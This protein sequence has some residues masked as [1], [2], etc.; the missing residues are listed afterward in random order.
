[1]KKILSVLG[2]VVVFAAIQLLMSIAVM[3]PWYVSQGRE[4]DDILRGIASGN[5]GNTPLLLILISVASS[6]VTILLFGLLKWC[7]VSRSYLRTRPWAVLFWVV[8]LTL[9]TL[10]PSEVLQEQLDLSMDKGLEQLFSAMMGERW[11]YLAIGILA[12]IAE[13]MVFRGAILRTLLKL[14]DHRWHWLSILFSA[15]LFGAVHG[16]MPQFVHATLLGLLLGWLYYRTGSIIPGIVLH[17][18]NNTVAYVLFNLMPQATDAKLIDLFGGNDR[19]VWL[20]LV[21]SLCILLPSLFQLAVRM[22]RAA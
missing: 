15:L 10:I 5:I 7:P 2:Y 22:K 17:W 8:L 21:F 18:V 9:G 1:M 4:M 12:P 16:N 11:G 14:F 19:A 20:S 13:E 6:V 3:I